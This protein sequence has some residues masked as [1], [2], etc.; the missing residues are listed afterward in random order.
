VFLFFLLQHYREFEQR[1]RTL[2]SEKQELEAH[3]TRLQ[4]ERDDAVDR[5]RELEGKLQE[6]SERA[7]VLSLEV[8]H[9]RAVA[10]ETTMHRSQVAQLNLELT[11]LYAETHKQ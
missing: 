4:L 8:R 1:I 6:Q 7:F 10:E 3:I 2:E 5:Y 11:E 9:L